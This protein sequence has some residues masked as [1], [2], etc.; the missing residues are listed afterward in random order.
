[1]VALQLWITNRDGWWSVWLILL[2]TYHHAI[3][4]GSDGGLLQWS[5]KRRSDYP[6]YASFLIHVLRWC[7]KIL[8]HQNHTMLIL[9][10]F[11]FTLRNKRQILLNVQTKSKHY[12]LRTRLDQGSWKVVIRYP[13]ITRYGTGSPHQ[14]PMVIRGITSCSWWSSHN[15]TNDLNNLYKNM[16]LFKRYRYNCEDCKLCCGER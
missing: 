11:I 8:S 15:F 13:Q 16:K 9:C 7:W 5:C 3:S 12:G 2:Y 6:T 10:P 1:M 4:R 14:P